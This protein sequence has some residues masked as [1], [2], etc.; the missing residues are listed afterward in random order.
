MWTIYH[1]ILGSE[2]II[3]NVNELVTT[4]PNSEMGSS[5]KRKKKISDLGGTLQW[6]TGSKVMPFNG[7]LAGDAIQ[8]PQWWSAAGKIQIIYR[9]EI[10]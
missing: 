1:I 7:M 5:K 9:T 4:M 6:N 3:T 8:V 10:W 2:V